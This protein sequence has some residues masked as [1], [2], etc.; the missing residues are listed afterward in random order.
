MGVGGFGSDRMSDRS[1]MLVFRQHLSI[2]EVV[3]CEAGHAVASA[4]VPL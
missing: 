4:I 1:Q 3:K 2:R